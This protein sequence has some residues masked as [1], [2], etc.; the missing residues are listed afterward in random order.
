MNRT[1]GDS[2]T[3]MYLINHFLDIDL[4]L[5]LLM[6]DKNAAAATNGVSGA[7]SLGQQAATCVSDYHRSPNFML[8]D[9]GVLRAQLTA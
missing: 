6:P 7:N 3:Q 9:V 2:N 5:G 4:G 8:V 1:N